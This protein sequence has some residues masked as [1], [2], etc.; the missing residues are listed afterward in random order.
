MP[1]AAMCSKGA[2]YG[3]GANRTEVASPRHL[4]AGGPGHELLLV[5][6]D[7][8]NQGAASRD[9]ADRASGVDEGVDE[10]M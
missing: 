1:A 6:R 2:V 5:S 9:L 4:R 8:A 7:A 3:R 10:R